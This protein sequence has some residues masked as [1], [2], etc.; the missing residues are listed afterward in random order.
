[1]SVLHLTLQILAGFLALVAAAK[2]HGRQLRLERELHGYWHVE[3]GGANNPAWV[4]SFWRRDRFRFWSLV[5]LLAAAFGALALVVG[6]NTP[7]VPLRS[8]VPPA[9]WRL[10]FA[11]L[12]ALLWAPIFTFLGLGALSAGRVQRLL[13]APPPE[14]PTPHHGWREAA[15]RGSLLWWLLAVLLLGAMIL[16]SYI[17]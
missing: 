15:R 17:A 11:L 12:G 10:A 16:L 9:A 5:A 6:P 13:R 7:G 14:L 8:A 2:V 1:V 3:F 4:E